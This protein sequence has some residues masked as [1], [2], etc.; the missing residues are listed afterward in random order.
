MANIHPSRRSLPRTHKTE[1]AL[2][3]DGYVTMREL[4]SATGLART[5]LIAMEKQG[6]FR[7]ALL[8]VGAVLYFKKDE[9]ISRLEEQKLLRPSAIR[10]P[11]MH[12]G[13]GATPYLPFSGEQAAQVFD[14]LEEGLTE[15][16]VVVQRKI[17]PR[18]VSEAA[19]E[20][21]RLKGEIILTR[22]R[23][24]TINALPLDGSFPITTADEVVDLLRSCAVE[25]SCGQCRKR[26]RVICEPCSL[27]VAKKY[28]ATAD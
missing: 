7:P 6:V 19:I 27:K 4:A 9:T 5:Y 25:M 28:A 8:G 26:A 12:R 18:I 22:D 20:Y 24:K 21:R 23:I 14:A 3:D 11:G 13:H 17:H 2:K 15:V 16:E 10:S 1:E